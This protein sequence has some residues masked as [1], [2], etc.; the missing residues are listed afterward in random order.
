[1]R[2]PAIPESF[3]RCSEGS[4]D[5]IVMLAECGLF[6][7]QRAGS[8]SAGH[9]YAYLYPCRVAAEVCR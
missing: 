8:S 9:Q 1:V 7:C 6:Y 5:R 4:R 3:V 2:R